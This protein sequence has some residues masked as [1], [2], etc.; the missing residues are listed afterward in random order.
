MGPEVGSGM[1]LGFETIGN[2][3]LIC[4]DRRPVLAT[5]PWLQGSAFFGSWVLSHEVPEPQ[6]QAVEACEYVWI[7]HGH[8][9]HLSWESLERLRE[10]TFLVPNHFGERL[11]REL[12]GRGFKV[13]LLLDRVWKQLSPRIRVLSIPDYNQDAVLLVELGGSLLVNVNDAEERGWGRFVRKVA[14]GFGRSFLLAPPRNPDAPLFQLYDEDG[15]WV[16]VPED[17][18][19]GGVALARRAELLGVRYVVPFS[20]MHRYQRKDSLWA[21]PYLPRLDDCAATFR[22]RTSELTPAFV[23][24]DALRDDLRPI[25]PA[26]RAI[27]PLCCRAKL[28]RRPCSTPV[29]RSSAT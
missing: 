17:D 20:G 22:S 19:P 9:D 18:V 15:R 4:H 10:K 14:A 5:D 7:S 28:P 8:P 3:T 13:K 6:R 1:E 25:E 23:R 11:H 29:T 24:Y 12:Q 2:A 16:P 26:P 27:V 21:A